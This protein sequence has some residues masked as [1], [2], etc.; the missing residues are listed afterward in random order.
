MDNFEP[1]GGDLRLRAAHEEGD[2]NLRG[3]ILFI[4]ILVLFAVIT[5]MV[6]GVLMRLFEWAE[7]NYIDKPPTAAQQ[8]LQEQRGERAAKEGVRPQPDWYNREIDSR[9]MEKTFTAPRLQDDDAADMDTFRTAEDQ[10]LHSTAKNPDGSVHIPIDQ[11]IDLVSKEGL[12][13]VNG[14]FTAQ[15]A[16][17]AL[18][19][20]AEASKQRVKQAGEQ[21]K[22][23]RKK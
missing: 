5:L 10:W 7:K 2:F 15:P 20:E 16:L 22:Q 19:S 23:P 4:A 3:I 11:A 6:A 21:P 12:P 18:E 9:V 1:Q 17:G 13:Q 8:Q 14:T